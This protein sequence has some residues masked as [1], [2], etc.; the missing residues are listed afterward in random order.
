VCP[1]KPWSFSSACKKVEVS[2]PSMGRN[3]VFR[4]IDLSG[5]KFTC[6]TLLLVDQ[7][8]SDFC[9]TRE[10]CCR[11]HVF[12]TFFTERGMN[13]RRSC[14][15]PILDISIRSGDI[16]DRSL[17]LSEVDPNFARFWPPNFSRVGLPNFSTGVIKLNTTDHVAKFQGDRPRKLGDLALT[18]EKKK[19]E[20]AVKHK[21]AGNQGF[22]RPNEE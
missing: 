19:K 22:G 6:P 20:T 9:R 12:F 16:R 3:K 17:K 11:S 14:V 15:F 2:A 1:R 13:C 18:K 5:S 21:A 4:K 10:N 7:S 8:S